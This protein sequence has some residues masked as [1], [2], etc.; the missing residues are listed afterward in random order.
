MALLIPLLFHFFI[1]KVYL[2]ANSLISLPIKKFNNLIY[3]F[4]A[5]EPK[6][7]SWAAISED[8]WLSVF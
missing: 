6:L 4:L 8:D 2:G 3:K 1:S 7:A 5:I